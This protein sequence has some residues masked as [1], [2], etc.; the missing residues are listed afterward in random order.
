MA[1]LSTVSIVFCDLVGS[2]DLMTRVGDAASDGVFRDC[3]AA[4]RRALIEHRGTEV[5][6][7]GDGLMA[8]F[9]SASEAVECGAALQEATAAL[10]A[11]RPDLGLAL[12]VGISAGDAAFEGGDWY[13]T[14]VVEAARLCSSAEPGQILASEVV[15]ALARARSARVFTDAG[16]YTL[17]GLSA[18]VRAVSVGWER[19]RPPEPVPLPRALARRDRVFGFFVGR[20]D[21]LL[22]LQR[23]WKEVAAGER[24]SFFVAGEPGIGKTTLVAEAARL[25][26][27]E[28]ATVLYG[29][30]DQELS[31]PF[32]PF[33]EALRGL[34]ASADERRLEPARPYLG[35][36]SRLVPTVRLLVP[37]LPPPAV[38]DSD[39]ER[40]L[41]FDAV[42]S[43]LAEI[44]PVVLVLDDLHWATTPTLLLLRHL[45]LAPAPEPLLVL[46]TFRDTDL[47]RTHPLAGLLADLRRAEA[48]RRIDLHGLTRDEGAAFVEAAAGHDLGGQASQGLADAML[49]VTAGNP[50][51]LREVLAHL[52]DQGVVVQR[53]GRWMTDVVD[54]D[55]DKLG[56]PAG[57]RDAISRRLTALP[58]RA[59]EVLRQAAVVGPAFELR[60]LEGL[61]DVEDDDV[62]EALDAVLGTGLITEGDTPGSYAFV[63]AVVRQ[64]L[65]EELTA[66]RRMRLHRQVGDLIETLPDASEQVS[67]LAHHYAEAA[68]DGGAEKAADYA[69]VAA[70]HAHD[71]GAPEEALGHAQ[72]ALEA[73]DLAG[74]PD[75]ARRA[76][77]HL[78]IGRASDGHESARRALLQASDLAREAGDSRR[79][80]EAA[81]RL[82]RLAV[83]G[84]V[85]PQTE[86]LL[87]EALEMAEDGFVHC[88]VM[89]C[90][91]VY[92][93]RAGSGRGADLAEVALAEARRLGDRSALLAA[94]WARLI[95]MTGSPDLAQRRALTDE[96][97]SAESEPSAHI[98]VT[99]EEATRSGFGPGVYSHD[100][101]L[102]RGIVLL[103]AGD[104]E[105]FDENVAAFLSSPEARHR[106]GGDVIRALIALMEGRLDDADA[107]IR[108]GLA[109]QNE[110][111]GE[112]NTFLVQFMLL[113]RE[114][115]R[116]DEVYDGLA[117]AAASNR[118]LVAFEAG[119]A[120]AEA[121]LGHL[122][123]AAR[124]LHALAVD[125][126][127]R[128]PRDSLFP[129]VL[130]FLSVVAFVVDDADA[131]SALL[132]HVA[133]YRG[134]VLTVSG[135]LAA[136]GPADH[137]EAML[138]AVLGRHDEALE[139]FE[140]ARQQALDL[141]AAPFAART[142]VATAELLLRRQ[143]SG[144]R[145][146]ASTLLAGADARAAEL[147]M[148]GLRRRIAHLR[149][150]AGITSDLVEP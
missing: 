48:S 143:G 139:R 37:D 140:S 69:L 12:R 122:D 85:D 70:R 50:L 121:E 27:D 7:Q 131:A 59:N 119:L 94:L 16:E 89:A 64:T 133:A 53:D 102:Y 78:A 106:R 135:W 146:R 100:V 2:T 77:L 5:K 26:H 29:R 137:F 107:M 109:H 108:E 142:D 33:A 24:R 144:D 125:G 150:A 149:A 111:V 112:L 67:A 30:C 115:G 72:R 82:S 11:E 44:G 96:V 128:V 145:E 51:F 116:W 57:V 113:R 103:Q 105:R 80:A 98:D 47:A 141:R 81:I 3:F 63:H 90:L 34:F 49:D 84:Q 35:E 74:L 22:R 87:V 10:D 110:R 42:A 91:A 132:P 76:D 134:Q 21:E 8:S 66:T 13:G 15:V 56:L 41:L 46:A 45:L 130:S 58:G 114:Q 118:A 79:F 32:Q 38:A 136:L 1:A 127:P 123:D 99:D 75:R 54:L 9:T 71:R 55:L 93:Y 117:G 92:R 129:T 124:R 39:T 40:Q 148:E 68:L 23:G 36:V 104:R 25:A 31:A 147:G 62:V 52:V 86:R 138:L 19:P 4:W 14:P 88:G 95:V 6:A 17:K 73:L 43:V 65:L 97:V 126:L 83:L 60:V 28:G 101:E 18:P 20:H 120:M 61:P